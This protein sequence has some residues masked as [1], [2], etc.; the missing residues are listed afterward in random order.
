[1]LTAQHTATE[2]QFNIHY[3]YYLTN[4]ASVYTKV[5][6]KYEYASG[7]QVQASP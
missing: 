6:Y 7:V 3:L 2:V 4:T 5:L 1:M